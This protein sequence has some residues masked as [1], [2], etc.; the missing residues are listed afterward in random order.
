MHLG[1]GARYSPPVKQIA[2]HACPCL[3]VPNEGAACVPT[4]AS[5]GR[6]QRRK[7]GQTAGLGPDKRLGER[8]QSSS[9]PVDSKALEGRPESL[10]MF[11][12]RFGI[13]T[14]K[15]MQHTFSSHNP[16]FKLHLS[17]PPKGGA[18]SGGG[19]GS[20]SRFEPKSNVKPNSNVIL[21][22]G[23]HGQK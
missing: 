13:L 14:W 7:Q 20:P 22:N 5:E 1:P 3:K 18:Q 21:K 6:V 15:G 11:Y 17:H 23:Q 12:F 16:R 2:R 19:M 9:C 4:P 8:S 10:S